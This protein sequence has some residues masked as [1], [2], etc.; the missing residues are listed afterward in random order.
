MIA[1][2]EKKDFRI[3]NE[4]IR[5]EIEIQY[6]EK[7]KK[8]N[9][10]GNVI[11]STGKPAKLIANWQDFV[12]EV[13]TE[14]KVQEA[15]NIPLSKEDVKK[16]LSKTGDSPYQWKELNIFLEENT[17]L[18]VKQL[19]MLRRNAFSHLQK[20][21]LDSYKREIQKVNLKEPKIF[22]QEKEPSITV[23]IEEIKVL[24]TVLSYRE[25]NT[26]I[27]NV[28]NFSL[29]GLKE[30]VKQ[31]HNENKKCLLKMPVIFR[32]IAWHEWDSNLEM[33][34]DSKVDGI[35]VENLDEIGF[36]KERKWPLPMLLDH[37]IYIWNRRA[38]EFLLE[39]G[40]PEDKLIGF[41]APLE[42]SEK[43]LLDMGCK[44]TEIVVYGRA[45]MMVSANCIRST[46][47]GCMKKQKR[48][49]YLWI[50][51]RKHQ[52]FP[53]KNVCK[54]CYNVTYNSLPLCLSDRTKKVLNLNPMSLRLS[55]TVESD[56]ETK[57]VLDTVVKAFKKREVGKLNIPFTRGHFTG[58]SR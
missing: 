18:P 46:T 30:I 3:A 2:T 4:E 54:Y 20:Q 45:P 8:E 41:T 10:S 53:V 1:K 27:I 55:F 9:L 26:V 7:E 38:K 24:P 35:V 37:R 12:V 5:R 57:I 32:N 11:L 15:K 19:N 48:N 16:Q 58:I 40:I 28:E 14:Q 21:I 44:K 23:S 52:K 13:Q 56:K 43:E 31:I 25:I 34:I 50:Q 36:L 33:I 42:L 39:F 22:N 47:K 29:D 6:L 51:D 17:F 49:G